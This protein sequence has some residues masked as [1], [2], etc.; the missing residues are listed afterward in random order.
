VLYVILKT[1][2]TTFSSKAKEEEPS[3]EDVAA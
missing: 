2:L 3:L 1:W